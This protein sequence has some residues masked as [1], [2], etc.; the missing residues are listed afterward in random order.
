M[1]NNSGDTRFM[2]QSEL[3][4]QRKCPMTRNEFAL[5]QPVTVDKTSGA[6]VQRFLKLQFALAQ[7]S[8]T[9]EGKT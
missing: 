1:E 5:L 3:S 8:R 6:S 7:S 2:P 4:Y 9:R